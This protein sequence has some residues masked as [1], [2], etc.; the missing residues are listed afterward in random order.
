MATLQTVD[1][2]AGG[3]DFPAGKAYF[4]TSTNKFVVWNGQSWIE[5]HSD[6]I[7]AVSFPTIIVFDNESEFINSTDYPDYTIVH[8]KYTDNLYV[9]D[10]NKWILYNQN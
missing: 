8:A 3:T 7:G 2:R 9:W 10:S 1:T 6:G 4:E 5:L